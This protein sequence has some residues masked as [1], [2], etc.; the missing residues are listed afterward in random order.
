MELK[1]TEIKNGNLKLETK[2]FTQF[3]TN[4]TIKDE[5]IQIHII[6]SGWSKPQMFH[7]LVEF[8]DIEQTD[9][10][11]MTKEQIKER[12][13]LE[14]NEVDFVNIIKE[15]PNDM[16]LGKKIRLIYTTDRK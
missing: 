1:L 13:D 16:E 15:S 5:P 7:V 4:V 9:Y 6:K 14:F 2:T 11:F 10:H 3:C 8:G 12:W